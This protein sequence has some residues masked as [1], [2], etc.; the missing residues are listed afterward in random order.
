[1]KKER[2]ET[3]FD[4]VLA[5]IMT[6]LVLDLPDP[7]TPTP[8]GVWDLRESYFVYALSF[9]WVA[10]MWVNIYRQWHTIHRINGRVL[11]AAVTVLFFSSLVPYVTSYAGLNIHNPFVQTMYGSIILLVTIFRLIMN[12]Q[13]A[14]IN[15]DN[16]IIIHCFSEVRKWSYIDI[17]LKL[18]GI[19]LA[20]FVWP[21]I[22][23]IMIVIAT[24]T[25]TLMVD[26]LERR[27][28]FFA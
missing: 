20:Y 22:S 7:K 28:D 13:M 9:F 6:I 11:W 19:V 12:E 16:S 24:S 18:L 14:R 25:Y 17:A 15:Q 21:P 26:R 5:I 8:M 27:Y 10:T 23:M 1:M 4:A 2:L 3:F